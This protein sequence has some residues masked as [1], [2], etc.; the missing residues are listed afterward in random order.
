M[1]YLFDGHLIDLAI[2]GLVFASQTKKPLASLRDVQR[3][4]QFEGRV[5]LR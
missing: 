1:R 2:L 4:R 5:L 3:S